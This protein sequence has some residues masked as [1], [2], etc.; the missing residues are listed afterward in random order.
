MTVTEVMNLTSDKDGVKKAG[1]C[2]DMASVVGVE[3]TMK[4]IDAGNFAKE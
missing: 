4:L 2:F 3:D 1:V